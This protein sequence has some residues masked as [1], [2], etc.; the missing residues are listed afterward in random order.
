MENLETE[1]PEN[2]YARLPDDDDL[3]P[4][5]STL[6][7]MRGHISSDPSPVSASDLPPVTSTPQGLTSSE[8]SAITST[9]AE[10][11]TITAVGNEY[12]VPGDSSRVAETASES[13]YST[14][15]STSD[16]QTPRDVEAEPM[17]TG[18]SANAP[19]KPVG[20]GKGD[21]AG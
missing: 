3:E 17:R 9:L 10:V 12:E 19:P 11:G 15:R 13:A 14:P 20:A 2:D 1:P 16:Y 8:P 5:Y 21:N 6:D 4:H 7:D 18:P